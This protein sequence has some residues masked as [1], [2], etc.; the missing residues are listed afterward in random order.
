MGSRRVG[1]VLGRAWWGQG[2]GNLSHS[3]VRVSLSLMV[4][5]IYLGPQGVQGLLQRQRVAAS[6]EL[7]TTGSCSHSA[8]GRLLGKQGVGRTPAHLPI[9]RTTV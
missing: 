2:D 1:I 7:R 9:L 6:A 3:E 8:R 4:L 5:R